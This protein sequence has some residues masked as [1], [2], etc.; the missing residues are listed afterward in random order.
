MGE[1]YILGIMNGEVLDMKILDQEIP[2]AMR[3][4]LLLPICVADFC[5]RATGIELELQAEACK[6]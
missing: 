1:C 2:I 4:K 6:R 5:N 3:M